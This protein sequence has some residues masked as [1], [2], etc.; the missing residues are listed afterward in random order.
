MSLIGPRP[1]YRIY[2]CTRKSK[3]NDTKLNQG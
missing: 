2:L 3:K 1:L